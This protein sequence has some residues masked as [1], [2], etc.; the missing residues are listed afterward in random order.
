LFITEVKLPEAVVPDLVESDKL[1]VLFVL[2]QQMPL[3]VMVAPPFVVM[4][5]PD[6]AVL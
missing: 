4:A 5:P 3:D 1:G 2:L 6:V